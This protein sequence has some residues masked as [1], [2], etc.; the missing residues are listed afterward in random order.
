MLIEL[1][2]CACSR[3]RSFEIAS[4]MNFFGEAILLVGSRFVVR[5]IFVDCSVDRNFRF[6]F[7]SWL[8]LWFILKSYNVVCFLGRSFFGWMSS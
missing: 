8:F 3:V 1:I 4:G 6:V 2:A 7:R 5:V